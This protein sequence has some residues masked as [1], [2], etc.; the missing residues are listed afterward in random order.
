AEPISRHDG[1]IDK[2]IGDGV[3]A[4]FGVPRFGADDAENAVRAGIGLLRAIESWSAERTSRGEP[5]VE[6]GV[7]IHFGD[8]LA[9]AVGDA[10]R[11]E[12]PASG[13]TVNVAA[14]IEELTSAL[15]TSLLV[16]AEVLAAAPGLEHELRL[17]PLPAQPLRGRLKPIVLY[18]PGL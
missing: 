2:F 1:M 12:S 7:G 11:L 14:R 4:V 5:P 17:E 13:D 16:S 10:D 8:I 15:E 18:R 3:M 6:I 9:G